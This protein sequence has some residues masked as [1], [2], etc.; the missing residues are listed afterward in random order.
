MLIL[1]VCPGYAISAGWW[2]RS[3]GPGRTERI[4][5]LATQR[6]DQGEKKRVIAKELRVSVRSVERWRPGANRAPWPCVPPVRPSD[7]RSLR[8]NS[9]S[10]KPSC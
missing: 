5:M 7:R 9:P 1:G 10:W 2:A 6:F 3:Q 4:R 8:N